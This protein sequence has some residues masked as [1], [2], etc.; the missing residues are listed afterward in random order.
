MVIGGF[1]KFSLIDYPEKICA[2]VFSQGCNFRCPYCHNPELVPVKRSN[3]GGLN[4]QE[5]LSFLDRRK[6]KLDAVT[7]TGGEP[8]LQTDLADF[9]RELK[10]LGYL[11]KL[12]TNGSFPSKLEKIISSGFLDYIAMDIKTSL[13]KYEHV[14]NVKIDRAKIHD[15]IKLIMNSGID[16]EF[17]TTLVKNYIEKEDFLSIGQLV[18]DCPLFAL[19]R[20]V[21]FKTLN[22]SLEMKGFSDEEI[23]GFKGIIEGFVRKCIVR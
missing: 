4:E 8:F 20:F 23:A 17:R 18:K 11:V 5:I 14:A 16:Y 3:T 22:G 2:I 12:D 9:L 7:V 6:G 10:A 19:Q 1:H 21:S 15:S 13:D